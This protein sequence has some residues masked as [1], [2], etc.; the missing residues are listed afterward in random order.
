MQTL[1]DV[2]REIL[3]HLKKAPGACIRDLADALG[4][5][6]EAIRQ[7]LLVL[8]GDGWVHQKKARSDTPKVGRPVTQFYLTP[9]GDHL[10]PK[11]YDALAVELLETV[12]QNLGRESLRHILEALTEARVTQWAPQLRDKPLRERLEALKGIY[13]GED[14]YMEIVDDGTTLRLVE[15]NCPFLNVAQKQPALCSVTLSTLTRLLG[16]RVTREQT[17]QQGDGRCVFR[18]HLDAPID[19]DAFAFAFED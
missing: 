3:Y 9:A 19:T 18:L 7:H 2:R 1:S 16:V 11:H 12:S 13:L 17:F 4:L 8:K 6:S 10:F 15:R 14:P 5:S